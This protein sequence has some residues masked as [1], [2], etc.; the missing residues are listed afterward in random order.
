MALFS[1]LDWLI[2]AAVA[3]FLLFGRE[4]TQALRTLGRWYGRALKLKQELLSELTR[5]ADLP[6]PPAGTPLSVRGALLGLVPDVPT[7]PSFP[8]APA[9]SVPAPAPSPFPPNLP[10]TGGYPVASWSMTVGTAEVGRRGGS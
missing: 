6:M 1:D 8:V 9:P 10:W 2:I 3:V 7:A 5:A 4:N